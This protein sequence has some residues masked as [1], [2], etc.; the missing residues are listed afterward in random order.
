MSLNANDISSIIKKQI[1]DFSKK[2]IN[3]KSE[4]GEILSIGDGIALVSGLDE[5]KLGELL[6]FNDVYGMALNLE[7]DAVGV[8][9]MGD[10]KS[11]V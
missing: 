11:V 4:Q 8:V 9:L 2:N 6:E 7:E 1:K 3:K 10:R 5:V